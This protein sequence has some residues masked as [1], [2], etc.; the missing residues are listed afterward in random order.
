[1]AGFRSVGGD[2]RRRAVSTRRLGAAAALALAASTSQGYAAE[3]TPDLALFDCI[4]NDGETARGDELAASEFEVVSIGRFDGLI[5]NLAH[6]LTGMRAS[7]Q[8]RKEQSK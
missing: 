6:P 7:C 5:L 1:M 4:R 2:V 8:L 3:P